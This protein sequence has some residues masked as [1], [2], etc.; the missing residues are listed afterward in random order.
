[1]QTIEQLAESFENGVS[2]VVATAFANAM[3]RKDYKEAKKCLREELGKATTEELDELVQ[4]FRKK[5]FNCPDI[6]ITP[7]ID[8]ASVVMNPDRRYLVRV[9]D[10]IFVSSPVLIRRDMYFH[11]AGDF[12]KKSE[13]DQIME[14]EDIK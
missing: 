6:K 7:I 12:F 13:V 14:I 10:A 2:Q 1:M 8:K 4:H 5:F 9:G 11:F 3:R